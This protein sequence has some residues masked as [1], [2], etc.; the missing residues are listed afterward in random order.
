MKEAPESPLKSGPLSIIDDTD[1]TH[2][3]YSTVTGYFLQDDPSTDPAK[4]DF[5]LHAFGLK[6]RSYPSDSSLPNPSELSQWQ[7]FDHHLSALNANAP[8]GTTYRLLF[9]ARHG[10]GYHNVGEAYYGTVMWDCY[11][12]TLN[13]NGTVTWSDARLTTIGKTQAQEAHDF[14]KKMITEQTMSVPESWYVSPLDRAIETADITFTHLLA[15]GGYNPIV[16][17]MVREGNGIHTCDRRSSKTAITTRWPDYKIEDGF[18]EDDKLWRPDSRE[19]WSALMERLRGLLDDVFEHDH[20]TRISITAHS[21]TIAG[22]LDVIG[23]RQ[24]SLQTGGV[25]PVLIK[26]EKKSGKRIPPPIDPWE[27]KPDCP[28][29]PL[30]ARKEGFQ[31]FEK[32]WESLGMS[33]T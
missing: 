29:D 19:S 8:S 6:R 28:S 5:K 25:I 27:P 26:S 12:S 17:E 20:G 32:Y 11:W 13:G 9:L 31:N 16:K 10:Q 24:F 33:D 4:F 18:A 2:L 23:H 30:K 21:G 22:L 14:W 1:H 15:P 7:R 3:K